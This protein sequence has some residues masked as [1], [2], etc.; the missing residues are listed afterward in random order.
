MHATLKRQKIT[1]NSLMEL[2]FP[3]PAY[4]PAS[5]SSWIFRD[6]PAETFDGSSAP[7]AVIKITVSV[8]PVGGMTDEREVTA[9]TFVADLES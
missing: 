1:F 5:P 3:N 7:Y 4:N 6:R 2:S 9:I 8:K